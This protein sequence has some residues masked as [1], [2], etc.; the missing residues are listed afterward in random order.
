MRKEFAANRKTRNIYLGRDVEREGYFETGILDG[1]LNAF[2]I[3][4]L[5]PG[6]SLD[7]A[8]VSLDTVMRDLKARRDDLEKKSS[9]SKAGASRVN[10]PQVE[11]VAPSTSNEFNGIRQQDVIKAEF[12]ELRLKLGG[13][14]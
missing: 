3:T 2:T 4:L 9:A 14:K 6:A 12:D 7:Q 10:A 1:Y 13:S 8:I 11:V 5:K